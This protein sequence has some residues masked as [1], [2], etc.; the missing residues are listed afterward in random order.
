MDTLIA[1]RCDTGAHPIEKI[2]EDEGKSGELLVARFRLV[3]LLAFV[4]AIFALR[5]LLG[6]LLPSYWLMSIGKWTVMSAAALLVYAALR[7]GLYRPWIGFVTLFLDASFVTLSIVTLSF[8]TLSHRGVMQDPLVIILYLVCF[9]G[10]I[11][12]RYR[13]T[14]FAF[15]LSA[16]VIAGLAWFDLAFHRIAVDFIQV[17]DRMAFLLLV[18][19]MGIAFSRMMRDY[20][21]ARY[22]MG[23]K[24]LR[25]MTSLMEIGRKIS[26]REELSKTLA[27]IARET[28]ELLQAERCFVAVTGEGDGTMEII[29]EAGPLERKDEKGHEREIARLVAEGGG[30]VA[31]V[32]DETATADGR[33]EKL[34]KGVS[35]KRLMAAPV[36]LDGERAG[37]LVAARRGGSAFTEHDARLL[38]VLSEQAAISIRNSRLLEELKSESVYLGEEIDSSIHFHGIIGASRVMREMFRV[39]GKAA[40]A[41]LPVLIRGES[42][43]GKEL[44]A[45]ALFSLGPRRDRPFVKM[46]C[47][48]IPSELLESELF[49]HEKGAF[50]GADRRRKGRFEMAHGGTI[51][52]DE[53]GDMSPGLQTKL[54]RVLQEREFERVGGE[55][56][57]K[58]DV[59]II[60]ATNQNLEEKI[61]RGEFR[62]DLYYR[63]NGLPILVP[64]LRD[65]REDIPLL[66]SHFIEKHDYTGSRGLEFTVSAMRFLM[67][68]EWRGNV[69]EL[70]NLVHRVLVM[71]DSDTVS[72]DDC[73]AIYAAAGA[74]GT[75]NFHSAMKAYMENVL[76]D[77]CDVGA[78]IEKIEREFLAEAYRLSGGNV[79]RAAEMTGLPKSTL[80]N[81]LRKYAIHRESGTP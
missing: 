60:A 67:S 12:H 2:F 19:V 75:I 10:G 23:E 4:P 39:I 52:L 70:E 24:H 68:R 80:F 38:G 22:R 27:N 3:I 28:G 74:P 61:A 30:A 66:V 42:G 21:F 49:G 20:I 1:M 50:T 73:K 36:K 11:R 25:E 56:A 43:T 5:F 44:V 64:P 13:Y 33:L 53:I 34:L 37:V 32:P 58:V 9:S 79:R 71:T 15:C 55:S 45:D 35:I 40:G 14:I 81:K 41:A 54:L 17:T 31:I 18:S 8:Y 57:V 29:T 77:G 59:R 46:N 76:R 72:A 51:F 78:E 7:R 16:A 26:S 62:E 65:R 63:I 47:S 48:A 6:Y 69:R